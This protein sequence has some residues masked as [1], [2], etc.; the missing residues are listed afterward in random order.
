MSYAKAALAAA[1]KAA[2][3]LH[4]RFILISNKRYTN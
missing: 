1:A 3:T 4:L 2:A